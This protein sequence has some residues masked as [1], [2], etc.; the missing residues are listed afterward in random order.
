MPVSLILALALQ[1]PSHAGWFKSFCERH[2]AS[3]DPYQYEALSVDQLVTAF[4]TFK[5]Q[6]HHSPV[7]LNEMRKRLAEDLSYE[8]REIITKTLAQESRDA[9]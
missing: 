8:D 7:L 9:S 5:R 3:A 4:W 2:I 1:Q 6:G